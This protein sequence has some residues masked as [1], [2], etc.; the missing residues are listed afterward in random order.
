MSRSQHITIKQLKKE[1]IVNASIGLHCP[2]MT[3]LE[4]KDIKKRV[5]KNNALR[6]RQSEKANRSL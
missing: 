6:S 3:E 2:E 1:R 4:V 5:F